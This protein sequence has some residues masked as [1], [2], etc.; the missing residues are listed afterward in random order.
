MKL[1]T[2]AIL[3]LQEEAYMYLCC[4]F[5][6]C[7]GPHRPTLYMYL[8]VLFRLAQLKWLILTTNFCYTQTQ[9]PFCAYSYWDRARFVLH[10]V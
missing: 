7:R 10:V 2:P 8:L 6:Y 9:L 1:Q 4:V 3:K 5:T